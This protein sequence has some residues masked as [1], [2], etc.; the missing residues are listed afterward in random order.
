MAKENLDWTKYAVLYEV[1]IR[2]YTE[3]GTF[4]AFSEHLDELKEAGV[5]TLWF[6]PIHPISETKRSGELGSYYSVTDY[7][8]V[9][10]E[11]GTKEDFKELVDKAHE[12]GFKVMMDWIANH[13]GWDCAWITEHPE[14]YTQDENGEIIS[15]LGMGWP[16][17]A[18]LNFESLEMQQ[19]MI[20]CMKY[21]VEEFDIDGYRCDHAGGVP[22]EFWEKART[23]LD[24]IKPVYM[25]A[26]DD[27]NKKL[28]NSAFEFNYNFKLYD[29]MIEIARG[30]KKGNSI[31]YYLPTGYPEGKY[32]LNF[33]DNHDKNSYEHNIY[34]GFGEDAL[35]AFFGVIYTI[36]GVPLL[37][38][39]DEIGLNH[40]LAFMEK[41]TIDWNSTGL[42]Y[43]P[44]LCELS[45]L[46]AENEA[47]YTGID[48]GELNYYDIENKNI[49][50]FYREMN[51]NTVKCIFNLSGEEQTFDSSEIID[52][53]EKVV[54][55]GEG[56]V[57]LNYEDHA[58][59]EESLTGEVTL[60]PWEFYIVT[61]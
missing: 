24:K 57:A 4:N 44:L 3:E 40:S 6:M 25:L 43:R 34:E 59:T 42:N 33:L 53:T 31:K 46:R 19:E 28:L 51:G 20:E 12:M 36:P 18:D 10:P 55:H 26:E 17:V 32:T 54:L 52:Q 61:K 45:T 9:N 13:T 38:T 49:F 39:G 37:Y 27:T 8:E 21:W 58:I 29:V 60:K 41:D 50:S 14:W 7:R 47:L 30:V 11:F 22:V 35:P 48:G 23:E 5:N 1:N 16:D 15:P 2:Q 56:G